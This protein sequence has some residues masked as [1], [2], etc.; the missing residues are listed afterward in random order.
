MLACPLPTFS[1]CHTL[2]LALTLSDTRSQTHTGCHI[3]TECQQT[4][5]VCRPD[6]HMQTLCRNRTIEAQ[7]SNEAL[8]APGQT[9][10]TEKDCGQTDRQTKWQVDRLVGNTS[11]CSFNCFYCCSES[12]EIIDRFHQTVSELESSF[13]RPCWVSFR[14]Q[15]RFVLICQKEKMTKN[16][17]GRCSINRNNR[18]TNRNTQR[19]N[20]WKPEYVTDSLCVGT[21]SYCF[22][23]FWCH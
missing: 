16:P 13:Q 5:S 15:S 3:I 18:Y 22:T 17:T 19:Q 23:W 1:P 6:T 8:P 12:P 2:T 4:S 7:P 10:E 14:S 20:D 11:A 9:A 21:I